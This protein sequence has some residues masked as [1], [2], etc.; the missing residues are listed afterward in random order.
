MKSKVAQAKKGTKPAHLSRWQIG[1]SLSGVAVLAIAFATFI[2]CG[3]LPR[4][5]T[6]SDRAMIKQYDAV[7]TALASDD[8]P[9]AQKAA[10]VL[11]NSYPKMRIIS[12]AAIVLAKSNSLDSARY[13]F[14]TMSEEVVKLARGHDEYFVMS[15]SMDRCPAQCSPC[16]MYRF[17]PWVQMT[18]VANNPFMG[19]ASLHCGVIQ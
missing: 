12:G 19:K 13:A 6:E 15:C 4:K 17:G 5:L 9:G 10:S 11:S 8:L 14:L 3:F 7:R 1:L 18:P 16:Q 2:V